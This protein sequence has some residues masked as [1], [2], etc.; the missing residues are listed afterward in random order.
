[1]AW[2]AWTGE[3]RREKAASMSTSAKRIKRLYINHLRLC[4]AER[5]ILEG[6]TAANRHDA[7]ELRRVGTELLAA[8]RGGDFIHAGAFY[9]ALANN[10]TEGGREDA[11]RT[12]LS[13]A[14]SGPALWRSKSIFALAGNRIELD[15][16]SG[17][18][19]KPNRYNQEYYDRALTL[20]LSIEHPALKDIVEYTARSMQA[21]L[22]SLAGDYKRALADFEK[23]QRLALNVGQTSPF[24][25]ANYFNDLAY[26]NL[27]LRNFDEAEGYV[28]LAL[29][30]PQASKNVRETADELAAIRLTRSQ[31]SQESETRRQWNARRRIGNAIAPKAGLNA[32]ELETIAGWIERGEFKVK[33]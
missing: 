21:T 15:L 14:F 16:Q 9:T 3:E 30:N 6:E 32:D 28:R 12:L 20:S 29:S 13:L 26:V 19:I 25:S 17:H 23:L 2:P 8:S 11:E 1:M 18:E 22:L 7:H 10:R 33:R 31:Q 4:G 27:K 24:Y 5:L